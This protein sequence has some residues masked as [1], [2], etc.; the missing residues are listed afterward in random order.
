MK[1]FNFFFGIVLFVFSTLNTNCAREI[2]P[3]QFQRTSFEQA[4]QEFCIVSAYTGM[5]DYAKAARMK[6]SR[7]NYLYNH[8]VYEPLWKNF[9]ETGEYSFI[10][11]SLES[12]IN[13]FA[14]LERSVE[15]L[16][17]SGVEDVV[18]EALLK[19]AAVLPGP[20]TTVHLL[21][22]NPQYKYLFE[23]NN[24]SELN[25][26]VMAIT[27][28][29]GK[30]IVSIDPTVH[31]WRDVLPFVIAHEYHHSA[32][33]ARNFETIDFSL[34][35]YL[36]FEGRA[37]SFA[38]IIFPQTDTPWTH[39]IDSVQEKSVWERLKGKLNRREAKLNDSIMNGDVGIPAGS[40]YTIGFHIVQSFLKNNPQMDILQW[41]DLDAGT[42]YEKSGYA[43]R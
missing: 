14:G 40:G 35:E 24:L 26:G 4:G 18:K 38:K 10:T 25:T 5:G 36:V 6:S 20:N 42:I 16:S 34:L 28:G 27:V 11:T 22:M 23:Q 12:P 41:T 30:I 13:D 21:A 31:T 43:P 32:W 19:T 9:A 15:L 17:Q 37:D 7:M 3:P 39:I 2:E 8:F 1:K 29:A 33:T